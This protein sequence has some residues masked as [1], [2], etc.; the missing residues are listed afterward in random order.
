MHSAYC[1]A[2]R[3]RYRSTGNASKVIS[4]R[5]IIRRMLNVTGFDQLLELHDSL[6][7]ALGPAA[8]SSPVVVNQCSNAEPDVWDRLWSS[9]HD[10]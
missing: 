4:S 2:C 7:A 9:K 6:D 1:W 5:L 10:G 3:R 8:P